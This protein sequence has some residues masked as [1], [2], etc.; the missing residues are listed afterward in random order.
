MADIKPQQALSRGKT[1]APAKRGL[2]AYW[3][4]ILVLALIPLAVWLTL[5]II[6]SGS[7]MQAPSPTPSA[8]QRAESDKKAKKHDAP[9]TRA[10][11]LTAPLTRVS[12]GFHQK[13]YL[14]RL[15]II[16]VNGDAL[17]AAE[18]DTIRV[19]VANTRGAQ[20]LI[21]R[22]AVVSNVLVDVQRAIDDD[23]LNAGRL[24]VQG[25]H[26][27]FL[28]RLNTSKEQ[29][30]DIAASMLASK[31]LEDLE[32]SGAQDLI[33]TQLLN[34]FDQ[35]LGSGTLQEVLFTQFEMRSR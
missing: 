15:A 13:K 20:I 23:R 22:L 18:P 25:D 11:I 17:G 30:L 24:S 21:A 4:L 16:D 9:S 27:D 29:L 34:E 35:V 2:G 10:E 14:G 3:P 12:I 8:D 26:R 32:R 5:R 33:R 7:K 6:S 28:A 1:G 19:N 31:T